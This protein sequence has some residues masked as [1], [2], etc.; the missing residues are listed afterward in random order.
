[1][2]IEKNQPRDSLDDPSRQTYGLEQKGDDPRYPKSRL[3]AAAL[4][5]STRRCRNA[6]STYPWKKFPNGLAKRSYREL[7][8]RPAIE[9]RPERRG[10]SV[11]CPIARIRRGLKNAGERRG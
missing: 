8:T 4:P 7:N 3:R 2:P 5:L 1:M 10:N 9:D 6:S 11:G